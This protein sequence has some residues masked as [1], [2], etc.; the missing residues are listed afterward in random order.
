MMITACASAEL[1]SAAGALAPA[2]VAAGV[3]GSAP[4]PQASD[5]IQTKPK[6]DL[7]MPAPH[8]NPRA[9]RLRSIS[10]SAAAAGPR[11]GRASTRFPPTHGVSIDHCSSGQ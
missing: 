1:A 3:A 6:I 4:D 5:K 8:R 9:V 11:N 7:Y 10:R 2:S